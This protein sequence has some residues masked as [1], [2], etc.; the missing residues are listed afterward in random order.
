[1]KLRI[2]KIPPVRAS[3]TIAGV[4][5][6]LILIITTIITIY[7][8]LLGNGTHSHRAQLAQLLLVAGG[9]FVAV[10]FISVLCC[11]IYNII[12]KRTGG[13][14]IVVEEQ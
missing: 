5:A 2:A 12:A 4:C 10:Y 6:V 14:E 13:I 1:M 9:Y 7:L 3:L 8:V 11:L